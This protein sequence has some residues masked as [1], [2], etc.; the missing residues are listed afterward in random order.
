MEKIF[1]AYAKQKG[2]Q[3]SS[4]RFLL[5]GDT[6]RP[7]STVKMLELEDED[8]IDVMLEQIGGNK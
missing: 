8:Q 6:I 5:D 4:L 3:A 2:V 7:D 1:S